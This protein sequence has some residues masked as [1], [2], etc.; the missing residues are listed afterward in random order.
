[1]QII[2]YA[3]VQGKGIHGMSPNTTDTAH[4]RASTEAVPSGRAWSKRLIVALTVL[5]FLAI[6]AVA[7]YAISLI[8]TA[9]L[10]PPFFSPPPPPPLSP[11]SVV[12]P[13][14]PP[15]PANPPSL[16]PGF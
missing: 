16:F 12:P 9:G 10:L 4:E 11:V 5:A 2:V 7:L 6:G 15:P 1:M 14:P 8:L 3:E 13:P